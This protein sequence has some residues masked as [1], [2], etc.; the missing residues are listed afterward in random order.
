VA[1]GS[2]TDRD[3][4]ERAGRTDAG[5]R[6]RALTKDADRKSR[7]GGRL[8]S[9]LNLASGIA[10]EINNPLNAISVASQ[11]IQKLLERRSVLAPDDEIRKHFAVI[12]LEVGRIRKV[13]ENFVQ[14]SR[15]EDLTLEPVPI[16]EVVGGVLVTVR[17]LAASAGLSLEERVEGGAWVAADRTRLHEAL[18]HVLQNAVQSTDPGGVVSIA[19]RPLSR[20]VRIVVRDSGRG[21]PIA[22]IDQIF[23]PYYSTRVDKLGL[24]LTLARSIVRG[25]RGRIRVRSQVGLGTEFTIWLPRTLSPPPAPSSS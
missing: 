9:L 22:D 11:L 15:I 25:H 14:F 18:L 16:E 10:H 7:R 6:A 12:H 24:G 13:I 17:D 4:A 21:I 23:E 2:R 1:S 19:L 8:S 3:R 20:S 5:A